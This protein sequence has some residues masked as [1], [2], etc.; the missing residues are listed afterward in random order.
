MQL[1]GL[2]GRSE[3]RRDLLVEPAGDDMGKHLALTR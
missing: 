1:D 3:V 2:F